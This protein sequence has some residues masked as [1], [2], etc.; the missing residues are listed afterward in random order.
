M[1]QSYK[2]AILWLLLIIVFA[3]IWQT[4]E[5]PEQRQPSFNEFVQQAM[6]GK[7]AKITVNP[8]NPG[9]DEIE[10]VYAE[11]AGGGTF[12]T[13]GKIPSLPSWS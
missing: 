11:A 13:Q 2:T 4:V 6:D 1:K 7:V 5:G 3:S 12:I 9:M 10:G 8:L